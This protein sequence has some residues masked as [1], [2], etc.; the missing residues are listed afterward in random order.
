MKID[1]RTAPPPL[2]TRLA[3]IILRELIGASKVKI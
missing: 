3:K 2:R 1:A